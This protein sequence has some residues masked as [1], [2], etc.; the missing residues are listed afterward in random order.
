MTVSLTSD[1]FLRREKQSK[2]NVSHQVHRR[3]PK[4]NFI[5]PAQPGMDPSS[6]SN[7]QRSAFLTAL[8]PEIRNDIC[9][10]LLLYGR[11]IKI[12]RGQSERSTRVLLDVCRQLKAEFSGL[13]YSRNTFTCLCTDADIDQELDA[14]TGLIIWLRRIGARNRGMLRDIQLPLVQKQSLSK[15]DL[16]TILRDQNVRLA[17]DVGWMPLCVIHISFDDQW[18]NQLELSELIVKEEYEEEVDVLEQTGGSLAKGPDLRMWKRDI[19]D[20][21]IDKYGEPGKRPLSE[22]VCPATWQY[23]ARRDEP[24]RPLVEKEGEAGCLSGGLRLFVAKFRNGKKVVARLWKR[25][26]FVRPRAGPSLDGRS[27]R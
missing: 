17:R 23:H 25:R 3:K 24:S 1:L 7:Q 15:V 20:P 14:I 6:S 11:P 10:R 19:Y 8:P 18:L 21:V 13:Y 12:T 16:L 26:G 22:F 2:H 4:A 27:K 5:G 9:E